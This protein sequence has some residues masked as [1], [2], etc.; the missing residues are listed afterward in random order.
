APVITGATNLTAISEDASTSANGGTLVS[1]LVAGHASDVDGSVAGIAISGSSPTGGHWAYSTDNGQSWATFS[2]S[3]SAALVLGLSSLVRFVPDLNV[4]TEDSTS[5]QTKIDQPTLTFHAWDGTSATEGTTVDLTTTGSTGG[6]SAYSSGTATASLAITSVVDHV[7]TD[8]NDTVD[9]HTFAYDPAHDANWFEDGN[10]LNAGDGDDVVRLPDAG[11]PLAS[12]YVGQTFNAGAGNDTIT[13]GDLNDRIEGGDGHDRITGGLGSDT[14]SGGAGSDTFVLGQD[15]TGSGTRAVE[16][17]DGTT[18]QVSIDGLAG[19]A[20]MVTGGTGTDV[21]NLDASG[22]PGYVYDAYSAPSFISGVEIINGT[23]G[24]DVILVGN[25]YVSDGINGGISIDGRG[26]NDVIGGGAGNDTLLGGTGNDLLSGLGGDDLLNGGTGNDEIW[27]GAGNDTVFGGEGDDTII[28]GAGSD[29][30]YGNAGNDTFVYAP[31]NGKSVAGDGSDSIDGGDDIDT[32]K[33]ERL[34]V[35]QN[36]YYVKDTSIGFNVTVDHYAGTPDVLSVQNVEKLE[37]DVK[38]YEQV[39]L[40]GN[41]GGLT[42]D[43]EGN[44]EGNG[45]F[46]N[47]LASVTKV[48]ANLG[49]GNDEVYGGNQ[50]GAINIDG[51][52]GIDVLKYGLVNGPVAIDLAAGTAQHGGS[53]DIVTN[54]ENAIGT[55]YGDHLQGSDGANELSGGDGGDVIEGR[56][57]NDTIDAGAGSDL[58]VYNSGDGSDTVDGGDGNDTLHLTGANQAETFNIN[59]IS[60]NSANHLAVNIEAGDTSA[61]ATNLNY[62]V[63]TKNVEEWVVDGAGGNDTFVV[64]GSLSGTGLATSTLTINGGDGDDTLDVSKL[65]SNEHVVFNGGAGNDTII[66]G[67]VDWKDATAV[68]TENGFRITIGG[69]TFDISGAEAFQFKNGTATVETL[70][71]AAPSGATGTLSVAENVVGGTPV[72]TVQS[73][74][75]N[76]GLDKLTYAFLVNG[77]ASQISADDKFIIN[78]DTG[79]IVVKQGAQIDYET[80]PVVGDGHALTETVR[81]TDV[82]G[83]YTDQVVNVVVTNVNEVPVATGDSYTTDEDTALVINA[84]GVLANDSDVDGNTLKSVLV[85]GPAHGSLTLNA[86]GSFTYTP[87]A[88]YSGADSFT[89][90]ANDGTADSAPVTVSIDVKPVND[91]E[92]KLSITDTTQ[93]AGAPKVG[94]LLTAAIATADPDGNGTMTYHWL[95]NGV[96]ISDAHATTYKL[97]RDDVGK[98]ISVY[99]TYTDGQGFPSTTASIAMTSAVVGAN[100]APVAAADITVFTDAGNGKTI[101]ISHEALLWSP[102]D[103]DGNVLSVVDVAGDSNKVTAESDDVLF[104]RSGATNEFTYNV[105]DGAAKTHVTATVESG[106]TGTS[107]DDIIVAFGSGSTHTLTGNAGNDVLVGATGDQNTRNAMHGGDGHDLLIS[108]GKNDNLYGDAGD[109]V[110]VAHSGAYAVNMWGGDGNDTFVID[111]TGRINLHGDGGVDTLDFS[112]LGAGVNFTLG[113]AGQ[114]T[115]QE[116]GYE[117]IEGVIG[118]HLADTL[119]GN[120]LA[121]I[122]EGGAGKDTLI[123]GGGADTFVLDVD[124]LSNINMADV[125][126]DYKASEGDTL[127]VSK[128]LDSLLGHQATEAEALASVKTTVAGADTVV[129]V[130]ANGGW[131]DVAVLQNTT[132]A[133]KILYDDKH[134]TTTAPHVG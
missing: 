88:N 75:I 31:G 58:I 66:F 15:V 87:A 48:T 89:Y 111:Q 100:T 99:A 37:I 74:D 32:L 71:E 14:L 38:G 21:I 67:D 39:V 95:R 79:E 101:S 27:G 73:A 84:A 64:S 63:A 80:T 93:T 11:D 123:G 61:A 57:G 28:G 53:T 114:G 8:G 19:T 44:G 60:L 5:P 41:L 105:Y 29:T 129:S 112:H 118:T 126:T 83:I 4:Q 109:D 130:N 45:L 56:G 65:T 33:I 117:S 36:R 124:A 131:H 121:N 34:A 12:H 2:A 22:A 120:A 62:E 54:F 10:Y 81:V 9:L 108:G 20:D 69:K 42:V 116:V 70:V 1:A 46:L 52:D 30:L 13:G 68:Q 23:A 17:G 49:G 97:T 26:G 78:A 51:G 55:S 6:T 134:D 43:V 50:T 90:K 96:E 85:N 77:Q 82:H 25:N 86:D 91:G 115:F 132:E 59:A 133:V 113:N 92:A 3:N 7:F 119:T 24:N 128:L 47:E 94:D 122:L 102:Y 18:R 72:G 104:K 76:G 107:H 103:P 110:L 35:E 127:D 125:I 16:L 98:T 40:Q 106:L